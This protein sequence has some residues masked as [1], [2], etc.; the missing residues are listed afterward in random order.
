MY[1]LKSATVSDRDPKDAAHDDDLPVRKAAPNGASEQPQTVVY[2]D[3]RAFTRDCVGS[4]LQRS[5]SGFSVRVVQDP[6][7]FEGAPDL[8]ERIR[9]VIINAGPDRVLSP[10]VTR[11][12]SRIGELLPEVPVAMLSDFEDPGSIREA[13]NLGVRGYIPTSLASLVAV[14][15]VR[16]VCV[17]GTFA[18]AAAL[19]SKSERPED[20]A[21]ES[22][23][24]GFTLRQ[25][26]ILDCLRRGMANKLIANE[27]DMCE[28]T[29]KVHV[30][31]IMKKLNATNRTQVAYLTRGYFESASTAPLVLTTD[32]GGRSEAASESSFGVGHS[33]TSACT[34]L[35]AR[36]CSLCQQA[37]PPS[38]VRPAAEP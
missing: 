3:P 26:Q 2:L 27:L 36:S 18:P 23:I 6:D 33:E 10:T 19:P 15:A 35:I 21:G 7:Q 14:E 17:G 32:I 22:L 16:M 11:L 29:V 9:A 30:R 34:S 4:W 12:L 31:N 1:V 20:S 25:S 8:D 13:F 5:L 37:W 24:Q 38:T 28:S